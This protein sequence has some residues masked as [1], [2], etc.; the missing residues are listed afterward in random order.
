MASEGYGAPFFRVYYNKQEIKEVGDRF[1]YVYSE[2]DDDECSITVRLE[3]PEDVD[4]P[5][6]QEKAR[7]QVIW[8]YIGGKTKTRIVYIHQAVPEF[9]KD[10]IVLNLECSEKAAVLM[11]S[12]TERTIYKDEGI[13]GVLMDKANK[14]GL[15]ATV[16][17]T[18]YEGVRLEPIKDTG[19]ATIKEGKLEFVKRMNTEKARLGYEKMKKDAARPRTADEQ[20]KLQIAGEA[21]KKDHDKYTKIKA[22]VKKDLIKQDGI[23]TDAKVEQLTQL[24]MG[25]TDLPDYLSGLGF[26]GDG[27]LPQA[28]KSDKQFLD[29]LGRRTSG[30]K[31]IVN[32]RD[33][34][35]T[36]RKRNFNQIPYRSYEYQGR[37]GELISFKPMTKN[38]PAKG[39]SSAMNFS[40]WTPEKKQFFLGQS[41][42]TNPANDPALANALNV[43]A[44][45]RVISKAGGGK[46]VVE[47]HTVDY[48]NV[49]IQEVD[50]KFPRIDKTFHHSVPGEVKVPVT[51]DDQI[52]AL[53][54]AIQNY[55]GGV[56]DK[57]KD[58]YNSM[59]I[60]LDS[61]YN[62]ASNLREENELKMNPAS[63]QVWGD[64]LVEDG[65]V[66]TIVHASKKHS[67]NYY[68]GKSTHVID[69]SSGYMMDME[70]W[71]QGH[72][73]ISSDDYTRAEDSGR[74]P[75]K[76][77]GTTQSP[78]KTKTLK[79]NT[80]ASSNP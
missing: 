67:G 8:G 31:T 48:F 54:R 2:E 20:K 60:N 71:K 79:V 53:E 69:K 22:E 15:I 23:A 76:T 9:G 14:H 51:V 45:D 36:L 29:D 61:A 32:S 26:T 28:G 30:G 19:T 73:I 57:Q 74:T 11:K 63:M 70:L 39:N 40:G 77:I 65:I 5:E 44:Q 50:P 75:N 25:N 72:N 52:T 21:L 7:L 58:L 46:T 47:Y 41:D 62:Q 6:F 78:E 42:P 80:N 16:E 24:R 34:N 56:K 68:V 10:G 43:I 37:D 55:V 27:N 38:K 12:A 18:G 1:Q 3:K 13:L 4:K 17:I 35:I 64:P 49:G 59:G 66:V 33:D